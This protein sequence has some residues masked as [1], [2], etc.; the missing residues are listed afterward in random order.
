ME[1][2]AVK[3]NYR[4]DLQ[5]FNALINFLPEG[6]RDK[7]NRYQRW[8]DAQRSLIGKI[9]IRNSI[10]NRY[11]IKNE[12]I[13]ILENEFGKPYFRGANDFHFNISHSGKWVV[14]GV[15]NSP[16]GIDVEKINDINLNIADRFFSKEEKKDLLQLDKICRKDYFFDLWSLK[17]SYIKAEG[18]GLS[19][20]L[21]TFSI[22]KKGK[23]ISIKGVDK[24]YYLKQ[25][26]VAIN[27]KLS[28]CAM[29]NKFP[30]DIE[31]MEL[32]EFVQYSVNCIGGNGHG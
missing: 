17:E 4:M 3:S 18:K 2:H 30:T 14:Y 8:E 16:I 26:D 5:C 23:I 31:I 32:E 1:I 24:S 29:N 12:D 9:L 13:Y 19:I 11:G 21:D 25:Y 6:D 10:I 28:V 15:D 7:I 22:R 20:P 27:Y